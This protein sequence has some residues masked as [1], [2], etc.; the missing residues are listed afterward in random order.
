MSQSSET[1][2]PNLNI[3]LDGYSELVTHPDN[4]D[5]IR[6]ELTKYSQEKDGFIFRP[7]GLKVTTNEHMEAKVQAKKNDKLLWKRGDVLPDT[8][9]IEWAN[10]E[11]PTSWQIYFGLVE[12]VMEI[13]ILLVRPSLF[14]HNKYNVLPMLDGR[15]I[16]Y[17]SA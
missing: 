12:P 17:G 9:F 15:R 5:V 3:N 10:L 16:I 14:L 7:A 13:N 6:R 8:K 4:L 11:D 1:R 2:I